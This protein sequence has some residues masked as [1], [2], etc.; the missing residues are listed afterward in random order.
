M[1][2][3]ARLG[4]THKAGGMVGP[5]SYASPLRQLDGLS[6]NT[7]RTPAGKRPILGKPDQVHSNILKGT[8]SDGEP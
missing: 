7:G 1:V 8:A 6:T 3:G 2:A 4:S 5:E